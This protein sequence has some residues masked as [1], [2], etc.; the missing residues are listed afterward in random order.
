MEHNKVNI[1]SNSTNNAEVN[2]TWN[3]TLVN[4]DALHLLIYPCPC[5]GEDGGCG[6]LK[7]CRAVLQCLQI[8]IQIN[9][10]YR[11]YKT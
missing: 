6:C 2:H 1:S 7:Q 3:G 8:N 10:Q 11:T 4:M 5:V 9:W